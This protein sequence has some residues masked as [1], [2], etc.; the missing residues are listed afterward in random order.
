MHHISFAFFFL[1]VHSAADPNMQLRCFIYLQALNACI[2]L[3]QRQTRGKSESECNFQSKSSSWAWTM[4]KSLPTIMTETRK[5]RP[6]LT[7][8]ADM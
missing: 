4:E 8:D 2:G 1:L 6:A 7:V 3:F 5:E